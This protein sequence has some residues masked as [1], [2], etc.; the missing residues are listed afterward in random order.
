MNMQE[1]PGAMLAEGGLSQKVAIVTGGGSGLGREM[2]VE[3]ARLG[4]RVVV[5]GRREAN[6]QQTV[7][8]I[9]EAGG[10]ALAVPTDVR[11]PDQVEHLVGRTV[12]RFGRVDIL[13]N[14]A[15]GNFVCPAEELSANGWRSVV[16]IVLDGTFYCSQAVGKQMIRQ[17]EGGTILNIIA[18]YAWTGSPGVV[19]SASA[20]AGVLAMTRTLAVEWAKHGIRVNAIAPGP[21]DGTGAGPQLWPTEEARAAVL[22]GVPLGRFGTAEEL[23]WAASY[24]VSDYA[25]YISGECL[26]MDGAMWLQKMRFK[27]RTPRG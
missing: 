26:T 27:E 16:G 21:I 13:V 6:L 9:A 10:E 17:G 1:V 20:K 2:A 15:A 19:H 7:A 11:Q 25:G 18:T 23:A 12:Q 14:N 5:A 3:F 8:M 22:E 4:A 24:L